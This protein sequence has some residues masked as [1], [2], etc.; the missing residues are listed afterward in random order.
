MSYTIPFFSRL[1]SRLA[2]W[3]VCIALTLSLLSSAIQIYLDYFNVKQEFKGASQQVLEI[4][5][6]PATQAVWYM[7]PVLADD[8]AQSVLHYKPIYRVEV[9]DDHDKPLADYEE[10]LKPSNWRWLSNILFDPHYYYLMPLVREDDDGESIRYGHIKVYL[11]FHEA[12]EGFLQRSLILVFTG[13]THNLLLATFLFFLFHYFVNRP[14][15]KMAHHLVNLNPTLVLAGHVIQVRCPK[16]HEKDELGCLVDSTNHLLHAIE[17]QVQERE[18]MLR[19]LALAAE[20]N[21]HLYQMAAI[22][23]LTGLHVRRYFEVRCQEE[24]VH[25]GEHDNTLSLLMIDI[26]HFK[27]INDTY[28]HL[29]G[30]EVL[31]QIGRLLLN[32]IRS[33]EDLAVRYGGEEF[34]I[35]LCNTNMS[36]AQTIAERIRIACEQQDFFTESGET[37]KVTL[38]VGIACSYP[39]HPLPCEHLLEK[40]DK[41][42]YSAKQNGRNQVQMDLH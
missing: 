35:L 38:S 16:G 23:D 1:S 6:K 36:Q 41:M 19:A 37:L 3:T 34:L 42:L 30:D 10:P 11:D 22:D 7:D 17:T 28:G 9:L 2:I 24:F 39:K 27:R 14:L 20:Q 26:D 33:N 25:M 15:S 4:L 13:T 12:T 31:R 18:E 21:A 32:E 40:A 8:V 5:R 29:Q